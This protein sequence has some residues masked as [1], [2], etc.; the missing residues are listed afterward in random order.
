MRQGAISDRG[1]RFGET[2]L[3]R[4]NHKC[5]AALTIGDCDETGRYGVVLTMAG[6]LSRIGC[7]FGRH[8][9]SRRD[10]RYDGHVKVGPCRICKRELEKR[11]DG[12][13]VVRAGAKPLNED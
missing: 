1:V 10:V 5:Q 6:F 12:R 9:P 13:W 8:A 11:A 2:H 4:I 7:L 3:G